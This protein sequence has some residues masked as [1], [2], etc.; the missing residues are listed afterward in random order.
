MDR[1]TS[2]G[3]GDPCAGVYSRV[4]SISFALRNELHLFQTEKDVVSG[5]RAT[6]SVRSSIHH[7]T[8]FAR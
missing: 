3:I 7:I 2:W 5:R 8:W 6:E 4:S 1:E